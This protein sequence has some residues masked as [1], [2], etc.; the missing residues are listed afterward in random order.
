MPGAVVLA[1]STFLETYR[2]IRTEIGPGVSLLVG[3]PPATPLPPAVASRAPSAPHFAWDLA[4][5]LV[6]L[7][8][9]GIGWTST[10]RV[11][12]GSRIAIAPVLGM[13]MMGLIGTALARAGVR[14]AGPGALAILAVT[15]AAGILAAL[16]TRLRRH[17]TGVSPE[18]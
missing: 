10:L 1:S 6:G 2:P 16:G 9:A 17:V 12:I 4:V 3:P 15:A 13:S 11:P 7:C 5:A 8:L 14:P 18:P